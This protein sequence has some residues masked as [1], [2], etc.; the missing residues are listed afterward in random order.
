MGSMYHIWRAFDVSYTLMI[1]VHWIS[2]ILEMIDFRCLVCL[3]LVV[4]F[5]W[6]PSDFERVYDCT[7]E[8][9]HGKSWQRA[10]NEWSLCARYSQDFEVS[11]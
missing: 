5:G 10:G 3:M 11:E 4:T 6:S 7:S 8:K 9:V 2:V 1:V